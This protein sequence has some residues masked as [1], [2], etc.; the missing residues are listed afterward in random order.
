MQWLLA[1]NLVDATKSVPQNSAAM[2]KKA[3]GCLVYMGGDI[4]IP[5]YVGIIS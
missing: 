3:P 4:L 1:C 5:S 2:K